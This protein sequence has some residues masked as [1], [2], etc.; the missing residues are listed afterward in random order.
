MNKPDNERVTI[1]DIR[2]PFWSMVVFMVKASIAAI[3]AFIIL[4]AIGSLIFAMLGALFR[5]AYGV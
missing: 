4:S 5:G 3:P 2:M 1:V